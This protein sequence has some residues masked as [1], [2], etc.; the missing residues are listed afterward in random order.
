MT[1][2]RGFFRLWLFAS[3]IWLGVAALVSFTGDPY[4]PPVYVGVYRD[5]NVTKVAK[6]SEEAANLE[7]FERD[8]LMKRVDL[9]GFPYATY[10]ANS[11]LDGQQLREQSKRVTDFLQTDVASTVAEYR[12]SGWRSFGLFG[13]LPP[14]SILIFGICFAW[15]AAGFT[16]GRP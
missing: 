11:K 6:Y 4:F 14:I 15:I 16:G 9:V 10:F 5:G 12:A 13:V 7:K 1:W 8:G 2:A 3:A